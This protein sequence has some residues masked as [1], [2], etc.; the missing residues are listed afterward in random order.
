[1]A[2]ILNVLLSLLFVIFLS[3][4]DLLEEDDEQASSNTGAG[5]A[6]PTEGSGEA[7]P[8]EVR[9]SASSDFNCTSNWTARDGAFGL[10]AHTGSGTCEVDFPGVSAKYK[11]KIKVQTERD[12]APPYTV[13]IGGKTVASDTY[14][15]ATG[16]LACDCSYK[17]CPDKD[18]SISIGTFQVNKEDTIE[19]WGDQVY[20]CGQNHGAYAK[21]HEMVFTPVD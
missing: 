8:T 7:T 6:T 3:S 12:G 9:L 5:E 14:P 4:C 13:S 10:K 11:I 1:M 2:K 15:Y 20:P 19:F 17:K 16:R 18:T 21:W